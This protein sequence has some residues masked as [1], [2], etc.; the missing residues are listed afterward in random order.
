MIFSNIQEYAVFNDKH[1]D[2]NRYNGEDLNNGTFILVDFSCECSNVI[3]FKPNKILV[4][5]TVNA[6]YDDSPISKALIS[7][8]SICCDQ[9][10]TEK[11]DYEHPWI[12]DC[13]LTDEE[14]KT[15]SD[16]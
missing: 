7:A 8:Y 10:A 6:Q 11:N 16:F 2:F 12:L 4:V 1:L 3:L 5:N 13:I 14:V 15:I 9:I